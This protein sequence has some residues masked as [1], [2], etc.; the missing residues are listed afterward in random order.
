M[1]PASPDVAAQER[2]EALDAVRRAMVNQGLPV[3]GTD[4]PLGLPLDND[5]RVPALRVTA[6]EGGEHD[7]RNT[8]CT[9]FCRFLS[10]QDG[11]IQAFN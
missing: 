1:G 7:V 3:A 5:R 2:R 6:L 10:S 4:N 11:Y 9:N 8:Q